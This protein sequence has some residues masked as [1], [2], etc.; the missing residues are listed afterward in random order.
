MTPEEFNDLARRRSEMLDSHEKDCDRLRCDCCICFCGFAEY[1]LADLKDD[2]YDA[3]PELFDA[4]RQAWAE[5]DEAID[6]LDA[7]TVR[8]CEER[9]ARPDAATVA[10]VVELLHSIED[11]PMSNAAAKLLVQALRLLEK[12]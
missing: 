2:I 5:R 9:D 6:A 1:R 10:E 11:G 4:L 8:L 7:A 3:A 12:P